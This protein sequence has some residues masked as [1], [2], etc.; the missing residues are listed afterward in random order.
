M[1]IEEGEILGHFISPKGIQVNPAK[2][3]V[4][5]TLPT[6]TK[7][8]DVW[9]FLSHVGYYKRF[10]KDFSQLVTQLYNLLKKDSKFSWDNECDKSFL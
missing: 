9:S 7:Y 6:P 10:I 8:K 4:I 1:M 5:N 2:I 3:E